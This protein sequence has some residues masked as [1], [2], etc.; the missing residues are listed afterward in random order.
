MKKRILALLLAVFMIMTALV[1]CIGD[2]GNDGDGGDGDKPKKTDE[3]LIKERIAMFV[4][5]FDDVDSDAFLG[6]FDA[7]TRNTMNASLNLVGGLLGSIDLR[8]IFTLTF[9][10]V[11]GGTLAAT[12]TAVEINGTTAKATANV[13]VGTYG[14]YPTYFH[15]VKENGGWYITELEDPSYVDPGDGEEKPYFVSRE[16]FMGGYAY[17]HYTLGGENHFVIVNTDGN[18]VYDSDIGYGWAGYGEGIFAL[19]H[20]KTDGDGYDV[21]IR[22]AD[23]SL[24][25]SSKDGAFDQIICGGDGYVALYKKEATMTSLTHK[26]GVLGKDGSWVQEM[27]DVADVM[28]TLGGEFEVTYRGDDIFSFCGPSNKEIYFNVKTGDMMYFED[29]YY[30]T[31][32]FTDGVIFAEGGYKLDSP[33]EFVDNPDEKALPGRYALYSSLHDH[34]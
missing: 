13:T 29:V 14:P 26:L 19:W 24:L 34:K 25:L 10:M 11:P 4:D 9:A 18:V 7:R 16:N 28:D 31:E 6:C 27:T 12:V 32:T 33:A 30:L 17:V 5:S 20:E 2:D 22:K 21:E 1:S 8:D 3:E 23:G 15:M